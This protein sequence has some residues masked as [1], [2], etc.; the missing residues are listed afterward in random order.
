MEGGVSIT[1]RDEEGVI[2][3]CQPEDPVKDTV[4]RAEA[5]SDGGARD[6]DGGGS[7]AG[8]TSP[9]REAELEAEVS[10]LTDE[11]AGLSEEVSALHVKVKEEKTK[12]KQLWRDSCEQLAEY[13][14]I[15]GEREVEIRTLKARIAELEMDAHLP[16]H[17]VPDDLLTRRPVHSP[18]VPHEPST[19]SGPAVVATPR[20]TSQPTTVR[21][22]KAPP[23][24]SFDGENVEVRFDDWFP[25][26]QRAATW[27]GWSEEETLI[28]LAGHLRKRALHK[29]GTFLV[30]V[31]GKH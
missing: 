8:S 17:V 3:G 19:H 20:P 21:S 15:I 4:S 27:N 14:T 5:E 7:R 22:G 12:Y 31:T 16:V 25:M 1:L 30:V 29:S 28:Q 18:I 9:D 11:N 26:L 13:D 23:I 24:D 2:L 10:R 6:L